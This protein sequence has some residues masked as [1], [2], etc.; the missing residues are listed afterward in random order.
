MNRTRKIVSLAAMFGISMALALTGCHPISKSVRKEIDRDLPFAELR[1][2]PDTYKGKIVILGGT[3]IKTEDR[4]EETW[5]EVHQKRLGIMAEPKDGGETG[6]RFLI[7]YAGLLDPKTYEEGRSITV[8]GEVLGKKVKKPSDSE[9]D[10]LYPVVRA[11]DIHL[12][13]EYSYRYDPYSTHFGF[14]YPYHHHW[15]PRHYIWC[16]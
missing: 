12:W 8:A 14:Y 7:V 6:G 4:Q 9:E 10:Y 13:P 5:I 16:Y 11:R 2:D 3:I 1:K 15:Y